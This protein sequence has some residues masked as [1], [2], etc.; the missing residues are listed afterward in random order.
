MSSRT[1]IRT[2]YAGTWF[3]SRLEA[4]WAAF[5]DSIGWTWE[6]EPFDWDGYIPDFLVLGPNAFVVEVKPGSSLRELKPA[7]VKAGRACKAI[8][9]EQ[10][11]HDILAV[12]VTPLLEL[13][14]EMMDVGAGLLLQWDRFGERFTPDIAEADWYRCGRADCGQ[15]GVI[16]ALGSWRGYPCGHYDG[17]GYLGDLP[18]DELERRWA[19]ARNQTQWQPCP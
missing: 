16:H 8:D 11:L 4:R 10:R 7:L 5:M 3:R 15:I 13:E 17:D 14:P 18:R 12:G 19:H 1:A 9:A 2:S 6:Y